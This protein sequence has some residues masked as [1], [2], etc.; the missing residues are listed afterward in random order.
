MLITYGKQSRTALNPDYTKQTP[1][2]QNQEPKPKWNLDTQ[3]LEKENITLPT[4]P[5]FA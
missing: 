5:T 3:K 1:G 4:S 2:E